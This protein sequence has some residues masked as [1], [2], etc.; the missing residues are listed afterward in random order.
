MPDYPPEYF[1]SIIV[2]LFW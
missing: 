1:F 2:F